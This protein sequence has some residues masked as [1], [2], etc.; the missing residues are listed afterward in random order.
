MLKSTVDAL[1]MGGSTLSSDGDINVLSNYTN[2]NQGITTVADAAKDGLALGANVILNHYG[3]EITSNIA[4]DSNILKSGNIG[5][6]AKSSEYINVIPVAISFATGGAGAVAADVVVNVIEDKTNAIAAGILNTDGNL[7]VAADGE[8]TIY[9]RGGTLAVSS[10]NA[11]AAFGGAINVDYIGKTVN[12]KIG[13]DSYTYTDETGNEHTVKNKVKAEGNVSATAVSTNS[14]GG[15]PT[16]DNDNN[17]NRDDIT[18]STYQDNL[19][20]KN[21]NGEYTGINYNNDFSNWNMFYNLS[22]GANAA[23][24]GTVIVKTIENEVTAE[25]SNADITSSALNIK[26]EDYSIKNNLYNE[27]SLLCIIDHYRNMIKTKIVGGNLLAILSIAIPAVLSF[28]TKDGFDFNGLANAL[29][30][31]LTGKKTFDRDHIAK[32]I[33][34]EYLKGE[35]GMIER[36][37]E[38]FSELYFECINTDNAEKK[39]ES[40]K[41]IKRKPKAS[42]K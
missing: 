11:L 30:S 14:I 34:E 23:I 27:K 16:K 2:I 33:K 17:Y 6:G 29:N 15:T 26:A 5:V 12:A 41:Q 35:D 9:N 32:K 39:K 4:N 40:K 21:S 1:V 20:K 3:N 8:T 22:A 36:L 42:K 25:I 13:G 38:I 37:E 28:Y 19:M 18:S 7:T 31:V 24:S 10:A